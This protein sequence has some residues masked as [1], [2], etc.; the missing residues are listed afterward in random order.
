MREV[1]FCLL[2]FFERTWNLLLLLTSGNFVLLRS[3]QPTAFQDGRKR[4][5]KDTLMVVRIIRHKP[6]TWFCEIQ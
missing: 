1:R 5:R 4:K 2:G 3:P 6:P